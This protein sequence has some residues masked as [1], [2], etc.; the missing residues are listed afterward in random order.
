MRRIHFRAVLF[1]SLVLLAF[2]FGALPGADAVPPPPPELKVTEVPEALKLALKLSPFYKKYVDAAGFPVLGSEK[3]QDAAMLEAARIVNKM[4]EGR[5]DIRAAIVKN[6][7]RLAVMARSEQTTDIPEHSDLTP[8]E[9]WNKRARG[10]G[11]THARPAVSCDECNVLHLPG[12]RYPNENILVHEF[13]HVIHEMGLNSIDPKFDRELSALYTAST[14]AR[15]LWHRT[16][17]AENYKE[18]W[19]EGVQ[20]YFDTNDNNNY[21]HNDIDTRAKLA[22]YD[23]DFFAL[24]DRVFKQ[25]AWHYERPGKQNPPRKETPEAALHIENKSGA[26]AVLYRLIGEKEVEYTVI[27]KDRTF[28]KIASLGERFRAKIKGQ[29]KPVDFTAADAKSEW[30]LK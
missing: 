20:S 1:A 5:D 27:E 26:E 17:A 30:I 28:D 23:P 9:Y 4:L 19:A 15:R 14:Q 25:N 8:K 13:G 2:Q 10:L 16:Y 12:D 24:I 18:F 7:I 6:R 22:V 29:E 21:Q 3:V 11:A